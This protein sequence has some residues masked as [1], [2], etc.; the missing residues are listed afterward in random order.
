MIENVISWCVFGFIAGG[1]SRWLTPG[2]DPMGCLMTIGLGITGSFLCG[3]VGH[4]LFARSNE[5]FQPAGIICAII[6][7]I[8]VLLIFLIIMNALAI[9]LRRRFE[10]KW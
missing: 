8:V 2:P 5:G 9:L 1:I 4:V 6:G 3:A 7:G 10:R